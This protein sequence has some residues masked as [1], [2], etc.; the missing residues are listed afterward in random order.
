M[1]VR[2]CNM[3]RRWIIL[4]KTQS[5]N[6]WRTLF[7]HF[8]KCLPP[9]TS[10]YL[11]YVF[12][13]DPFVARAEVRII[14]WVCPCVSKR[15]CTPKINVLSWGYDWYYY[16]CWVR[17]AI[18]PTIASMWISL[19]LR[20]IQTRPQSNDVHHFSATTAISWCFPGVS[21]ESGESQGSPG[22]GRAEGVEAGKGGAKPLGIKIYR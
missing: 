4:L 12:V 15:C 8:C 3:E 2:G 19:K 22:S 13:S 18:P 7:H 16:Y 10:I 9:S 5:P 6:L 21:G 11:S 20:Y 17:E 1:S 14:K